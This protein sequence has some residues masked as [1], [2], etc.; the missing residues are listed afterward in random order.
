MDMNTSNRRS[1]TRLWLLVPTLI[2]ALVFV[3]CS[4]D[5]EKSDS[6][7][8]SET[9]QNQSQMAKPGEL[10]TLSADDVSDEQLQKVAR[11]AMS[12]QQGTRSDRMQ[13]K[14]DLKEKYGNPQEMDSTQKAQAQK[15][16]RKRQMEIRKK[17]M[18][19]MQKEAEKEGMDP[20]QFRQIMRSA[21]QDS[22]LQKRLR[23]AMKTQ[24]QQRMQERLKQKRSGGSQ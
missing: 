8:D 7:S 19:I 13:M 18:D 3:G 21:Q 16:I 24:M 17:Q 14:K 9:S 1:G 20:K 23:T 4:G 6:A 10:E 22:T 15:E 12:I 5:S 11:I 2:A